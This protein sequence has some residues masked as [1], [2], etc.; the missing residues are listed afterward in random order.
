MMA[1]MKKAGENESSESIRAGWKILLTGWIGLDGMLC[2]LEK[3]RE[4]LKQRFAPAF[5]RQA[6][7]RG[8]STALWSAEEMGEITGAFV[9]PVG[10]G[11][12]FSAFWNLAKAAGTGLSLDMKKFSVLQ[13]TIEICELYRLNPYQLRSE[14]CFLLVTD[15]ESRVKRRLAERGI[16]GTVIG[17]ITA[18][19][20]K[21]IRNGEDVR[22]IDRP[23]PDELIK[24]L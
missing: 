17:E 12:V 15:Q 2:I 9:F 18:D 11:G 13:E 8:K 23:S 22:Y 5:L 4:E 24:I 3:R 10:E 7:D 16:H 21:I 14:G 6:E 1:N 20:D 19:N